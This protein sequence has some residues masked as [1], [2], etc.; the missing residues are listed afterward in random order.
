MRQIDLF[1][2]S[3]DP[4]ILGSVQQGILKIFG[5]SELLYKY[6]NISKKN[7]INHG[8]IELNNK[9]S[10]FGK[11]SSNDEGFFGSNYFQQFIHDYDA[12]TNLKSSQRKFDLLTFSRYLSFQIEDVVYGRFIKK[13]E[14]IGNN[15]KLEFNLL[16]GNPNE[17]F[18]AIPFFEL[19]PSI[20]YVELGKSYLFDFKFYNGLDPLYPA[21]FVLKLNDV[22]I[23]S[24]ITKYGTINET[25]GQ[26]IAPTSIPSEMLHPENSLEA[27]SQIYDK[28]TSLSIEAK[29]KISFYYL[30]Q[31]YNYEYSVDGFTFGDFFNIKDFTDD[32]YF[33]NRTGFE[34][35]DND[36]ERS[37]DNIV[38]IGSKF[39]YL[40]EESGVYS[41]R[42]FIQ[43]TK[44]NELVRESKIAY[45][46]K[47]DIQVNDNYPILDLSK[48][49]IKVKIRK[50][51][52][53]IKAINFCP[54]DFNITQNSDESSK[55]CEFFRKVNQ[56]Q[57]GSH[58]LGFR[59]YGS[60]YENNNEILYGL[61][62]TK[63]K[64]EGTYDVYEK[65]LDLS[66][67][68][69]NTG[70]YVPFKLTFELVTDDSKGYKNF[71]L[72]SEKDYNFKSNIFQ[73]RNGLESFSSKVVYTN[74]DR[75]LYL[76]SK[77]ITKLNKKTIDFYF[78]LNGVKK[79]SVENINYDENRYI[80][81]VK[82]LYNVLNPAILNNKDIIYSN[83]LIDE[84]VNDINTDYDIYK[85]SKIF[86]NKNNFKNYPF[87]VVN[88]ITK[89]IDQLKS[90]TAY[91]V[92]P[93]SSVF[94]ADRIKN[95]GVNQY[96]WFAPFVPDKYIVYTSDGNV[97]FEGSVGK[98]IEWSVYDSNDINSRISE[99]KPTIPNNLRKKYSW[100]DENN[101]EHIVSN[102]RN[103]IDITNYSNQIIYIDIYDSYN[104]S[105]RIT[106]LL[107]S[108][109][110]VS[111]VGSGYD[112]VTGILS[113]NRTFVEKTD[114]I[115]E[116]GLNG[117]LLE[118]LKISTEFYKLSDTNLS[119]TT[120]GDYN[121]YKFMNRYKS[122]FGLVRSSYASSISKN[123]FDFRQLIN[124]PNRFYKGKSSFILTAENNM[125]ISNIGE[126]IGQYLN[127][128][129]LKETGVI[130]TTFKIGL[131]HQLWES[132][133]N[134]KLCP[135]LVVDFYRV[136]FYD[137]NDDIPNGKNVGDRVDRD[138]VKDFLFRF[139]PTPITLEEV[140]DYL[141]TEYSLFDILKIVIPRNVGETL[142]TFMYPY[143]IERG[144]DI[145][146]RISTDNTRYH[147]ASLEYLQSGTTM[148]D[149]N[150][151]YFNSFSG[152]DYWLYYLTYMHNQMITAK[153][154][155]MQGKSI[156]IEQ[157]SKMFLHFEKINDY[158]YQLVFGLTDSMLN[159]KDTDDGKNF[160][161]GIELE[162]K[163]SDSQF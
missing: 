136:R 76:Y 97:L 53:F 157:Y 95:R 86:L 26:Y 137:K 159:L 74:N 31:D 113:A 56:A 84:T 150:S 130:F 70:D 29:A 127:S 116:I 14:I 30:L 125:P 88:N 32:K 121:L 36:K 81:E 163:A 23:P 148:D 39:I 57:L 64:S 106:K 20:L 124:N 10:S 12:E 126:K 28:S 132:I 8:L 24:N 35:K 123:F 85:G 158:N 15:R 94:S 38:D 110:G 82:D 119:Y 45:L 149:A 98:N 58:Y 142:N 13:V 69:N 1:R 80:F 73:L 43:D 61:D 49:K 153:E 17:K 4:V 102:N 41:V 161:R 83:L 50:D 66:E 46:S 52:N 25:T 131:N 156:F 65:V 16:S 103:I 145:S 141:S 87:K 71:S 105:S 27:V 68:F 18:L 75:N 59:F 120:Q 134:E 92:M 22:I 117:D 155:V 99:V 100:V 90:T 77:I 42:V 140:N 154:D 146:D 89:S 115:Q 128:N 139:T 7:I 5:I 118:D 112:G 133:Y 40:P 109:S 33:A 104:T 6:D 111:F 135:R 91:I 55:Y 54:F 122:S 144:F 96:G 34:Y 152:D 44:G 21:K 101:N 129:I 107:Y 47:I 62:D 151:I 19:F 162:V 114:S 3:N 60:Y 160:I 72:S 37:I 147:V 51:L 2:T 9:N 67:Y 48:V 78:L 93:M 63:Y 108:P 143:P 79:F 11:I 138:I